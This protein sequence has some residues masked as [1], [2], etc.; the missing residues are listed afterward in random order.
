[1]WVDVWPVRL[2]AKRPCFQCLADMLSPAERQRANSFRAKEHREKFE[3]SRGV[4]R[5]LLGGYLAT[6]PRLVEFEFGIH[7]KP[8]LRGPAGFHFNVAHSGEI[9]L[10]AIGK[11]EV[12]IDIEQI[13]PMP[14]L[15]EVARRFFSAAE[16]MELA[17]LSSAFRLQAFYNCWARKEAYIKALGVGLSLPLESFR[18]SLLPEQP[19]RLI[20]IVGNPGLEAEWLIEDLAVADGYAAALAVRAREIRLWTSPLLNPEE[21]E[22]ALNS[23]QI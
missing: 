12:G 7:G 6:E 11:L 9:A 17:R 13:R 8:S 23:R 16:A 4:L 22:S 19:A 5:L 20:E 3:I 14:N 18:V 1:M 2:I 15:L 10:Y 21:L